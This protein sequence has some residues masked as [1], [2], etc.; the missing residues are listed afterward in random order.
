VLGFPDDGTVWTVRVA[1]TA[2]GNVETVPLVRV[3]Q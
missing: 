2:T 1:D 3:W